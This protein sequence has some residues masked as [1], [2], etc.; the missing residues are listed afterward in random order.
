[1]ATL[2]R[3]PIAAFAGLLLLALSACSG[4]DDPEGAPGTGGSG[5]SA[6]SSGSA[7]KGTDEA[8]PHNCDV[9]SA[10]KPCTTDPDPCG[11]NSGFEGDEYCILPPPPE[12]GIQIH[13]GP[14]D[15][16]NADDVRPYLLAAG[17]E[18]NAYGIA[19]IPLTEDRWYNRVEIR[20]RPGSHHLINTLVQGENLPEGFGPAGRGCQ[21]TT[22][23]SFAGTQNLVYNSVPNGKAAPENVGLGYKL[24]G[25]TSLCV[26]HHGYNF[27]RGTERLREVWINVYFVPESEVTQRS[28]GV[29]VVAGPWGTGIAPHSQQSLTLTATATGSGRFLSLFGHRHA[30]TDRFAV[31]QNDTLIYDSWKWEESVVFPYNSLI[32]NPPIATE[33]KQDGAVSGIVDI[34]EG[35][36][37]KIQCDIN[38]T[39]DKA[40]T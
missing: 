1:M 31:W 35:D 22:I 10:T 20:M 39:T 26:N 33:Q 9:I 3:T 38:N 23:S 27:D 18:Q 2:H 29:M 37:I 19:K 21:G 24:T 25:N 6:G 36:Q 13:F 34:K 5:G 40:L 30:H 16:K 15:Y 28:N 32:N 4:S 17:G 14:K 8:G 11:L 12:Q 7:G